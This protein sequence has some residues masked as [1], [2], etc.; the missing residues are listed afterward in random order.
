MRMSIVRMSKCRKFDQY[1][2][3]NGIRPNWTAKDSTRVKC[4]CVRK[5]GYPLVTVERV[6]V[7]TSYMH[8][9]ATSP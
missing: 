8:A 5:G 2:F 3:S 7:D 1:N 4:P 6:K 9:V